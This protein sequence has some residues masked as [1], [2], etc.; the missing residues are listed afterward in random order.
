MPSIGNI[1]VKRITQHRLLPPVYE[2]IVKHAVLQVV[3][4]LQRIHHALPSLIGAGGQS[5]KPHKEVFKTISQSVTVAPGTV[6][7][8]K[9]AGVV[10]HSYTQASFTFD[11]YTLVAGAAISKTL[12]ENISITEPLAVQR[13]KTRRI[14]E[15][16]PELTELSSTLSIE[17]TK[18]RPLVTNR[19]Y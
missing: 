12:T 1:V 2:P 18:A 19:S 7:R 8:I 11:S 10:G 3:T 5:P 13:I 16:A 14:F 9:T 4:E 17:R 15:D 6:N